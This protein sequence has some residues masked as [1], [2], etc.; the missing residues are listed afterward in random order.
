MYY[1]LPEQKNALT[2]WTN[3]D[4]DKHLMPPVSPT[5][6]ESQQAAKI[7]NDVNAY[8][9]E[10]TLKVIM[11]NDTVNNFDNYLNQLKKLDIDKAISIQQAAYD[12]FTKR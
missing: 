7:M 1:V 3:S 11:G 5:T 9:D 12:R 6:E 8:V 2:L 10:Y 4:M